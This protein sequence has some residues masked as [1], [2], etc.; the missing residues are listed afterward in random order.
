MK[1]NE[2]VWQKLEI[3]KSQFFSYLFKV[4]S[5]EEFESMLEKIKQDF[6]KATHFC[7]GLLI[8][9]NVVIEKCSDDG[10]PCG[11]AGKPILGVMKKN[12]IS[13]A[14]LIVVRYFGGIKLGAGGLLRSYIKSSA[15]A[16]S[17]SKK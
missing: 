12:N 13:N 17:N 5:V 16:I 3:K 1:T 11:T 14:C 8:N 6:K 2:I 4:E 9:N 10:E 15:L 7:Y